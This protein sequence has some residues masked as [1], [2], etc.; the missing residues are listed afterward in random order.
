MKWALY[1]FFSAST[2]TA[3]DISVTLVMYDG[4]NVVTT[5]A[6]LA[7]KYIYTVK[8]MKRITG[9]SFTKATVLKESS[10]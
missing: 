2:R 6:A 5:N 10:N 4:S 8:L 1:G 9:F 3:S 7:K